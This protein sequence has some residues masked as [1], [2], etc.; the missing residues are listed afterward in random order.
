MNARVRLLISA[1]APCALM[2]VAWC[3]ADTAPVSNPDTALPRLPR[4]R[5]PRRNPRSQRKR[6]ANWLGVNYGIVMRN[7]DVAIE[8][9][10]EEI[11][12]GF[13]DGLAARG[14]RKTCSIGSENS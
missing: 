7:Y 9:L 3:G 1:F 10:P 14:L 6:L 5:P 12:R 4:R 11:Q 13:R 2:N 8:I